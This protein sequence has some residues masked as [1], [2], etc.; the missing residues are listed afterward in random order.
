MLHSHALR[1]CPV[2]PLAVEL[3][4]H[5]GIH[6][7][8]Q[9]VEQ[10]FLILQSTLVINKLL[11][12]KRRLPRMLRNRCTML[13]CHPFHA[14]TMPA[15]VLLSDRLA[16]L[17]RLLQLRFRCSVL[18]SHPIQL[19]A[20][21]SIDHRMVLTQLHTASPLDLKQI[22]ISFFFISTGTALLFVGSASVLSVVQINVCFSTR[23]TSAGSDRLRELFGRFFSFSRMNIPPF[24]MNSQ[25]SAYSS[26][27]P[28]AHRTLT[29]L[30]MSR[31]SLTHCSKSLL[32]RG[33]C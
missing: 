21:L 29:G 23:A 13:K 6:N 5:V 11:I 3:H 22:P 10:S 18:R 30:R 17:Q 15:S 8:L 16:P 14:Q 31:I 20:L 27:V 1:L 32:E 9:P 24:T 26:F 7:L 12:N 19:V 25:S 2:F 33:M 28:V 4:H